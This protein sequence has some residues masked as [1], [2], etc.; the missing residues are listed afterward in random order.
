MKITDN[1]ILPDERESI[2]LK[3]VKYAIGFSIEKEMI[4]DMMSADL[5]L[6]IEKRCKALSFSLRASLF[7][8]HL[9]SVSVTYPADWWQHFKQRWFPRWLKK[10][11]PVKETVVTHNINALYPKLK[12]R[13]ED[14]LYFLRFD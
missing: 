8:Q 6:L 11:C 3:K 13:L 14:E 4:D 2:I 12:P 1:V 7:S 5:E 10:R 9:G